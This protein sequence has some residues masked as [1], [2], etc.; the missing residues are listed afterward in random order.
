MLYFLSL[1][2]SKSKKNCFFSQRNNINGKNSIKKLVTMVYTKSCPFLQL[3]CI[4]RTYFT[5]LKRQS[6]VRCNYFAEDFRNIRK[7]GVP[8]FIFPYFW[9]NLRESTLVSSS[10]DSPVFANM[11]TVQDPLIFPSPL[12]FIMYKLLLLYPPPQISSPSL[13]NKGCVH[14]STR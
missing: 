1:V 6:F 14:P 12:P 2:Y 3:T 11:F 5:L 10:E 7:N 8:C 13:S 9:T 4:F